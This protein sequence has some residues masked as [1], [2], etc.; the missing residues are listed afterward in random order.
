MK[1]T[2]RKFTIAFKTDVVLDALKER[3]TTAQLAEK[4]ELH[5]NQISSRKLSFWLMLNQF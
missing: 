2:R 4:Y 1:G 5:P 3:F